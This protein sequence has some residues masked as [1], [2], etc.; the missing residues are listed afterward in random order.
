MKIRRGIAGLL[1]CVVTSAM[2]LVAT[3]L[4]ARADDVFDDSQPIAHL[5][6]SH[7]PAQRLLEPSDL[8]QFYHFQSQGFAEY[9]DQGWCA[10]W[11]GCIKDG[12][13]G[14]FIR[15]LKTNLCLDARDGAKTDGSVVQQW[16]CRDRNYR[17]AR[18]MVWYVEPGE[19]PGMFKVRNWN[20]DLCL[21]VKGGSSDEF[22]QLQ[23][24]HCGSMNLAQNFSQK[25]PD[26]WPWHDL[27]GLNG[28]W[29]DGSTRIAVIYAGL[30]SIAIDM[31]AFNRPAA[32]G[33]VLGGCVIDVT[34]PDDA[35]FMGEASPCA[36]PDQTCCTRVRTH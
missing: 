22:A 35:T 1:A 31:S 25:F 7:N 11:F 29:T 24:F 5:Q 21:D 16:T 14:Y 6:P 12:T 20:S 15:N 4:S 8:I 17:N 26:A 28:R 19:F 34:F 13:T 3:P 18:S 23:Q 32:S 2:I 10:R 27:P 9:N 36:N 30:Q 33:R